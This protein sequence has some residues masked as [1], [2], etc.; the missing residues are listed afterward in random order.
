[1]GKRFPEIK[2]EHSHV[3]KCSAILDLLKEFLPTR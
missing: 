2:F 1:M 3:V